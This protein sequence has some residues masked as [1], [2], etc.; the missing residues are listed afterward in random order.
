VCPYLPPQPLIVASTTTIAFS[1]TVKQE[2]RRGRKEKEGKEI[3]LEGVCIKIEGPRIWISS[4][5]SPT[6]SRYPNPRT[7][8]I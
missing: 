2:R 5:S 7:H 3:G 8:P 4:I 1:T 6:L